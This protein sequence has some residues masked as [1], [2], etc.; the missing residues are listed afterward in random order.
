MSQA[1]RWGLPKGSG[2]AV[3][4]LQ[5]EDAVGVL[6]QLQLWDSSLGGKGMQVGQVLLHW[7]G[8]GKGHARQRQESQPSTYP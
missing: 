2:W 3:T 8:S 4:H 6:G 7:R 1:A 5:Q